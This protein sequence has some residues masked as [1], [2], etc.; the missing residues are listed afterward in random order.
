M[1]CMPSL[2]RAGTAPLPGLGL[3]DV[4]GERARDRLAAILYL[5][6]AA[7]TDDASE[8][9]SLRR[10]AAELILPSRRPGSRCMQ[11]L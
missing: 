4:L 8:R 2:E 6:A 5:Q 9:S 1:K 3:H 10:R 11:G 7:K